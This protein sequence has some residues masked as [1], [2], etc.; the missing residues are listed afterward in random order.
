MTSA[1]QL[2]P[3]DV[4]ARLSGLRLLARLATGQG[5]GSHNSRARGAGL[6]F[7]QYRAYEPGDEPRRVDWKLYARSDRFFVREAE[8]DSPLTVWVIVDASASMAQVDSQAP[9]RSRITAA[10]TIA[11]CIAELALRQNDRFGLAIA[12]G[13]GLTVVDAAYGRRQ[14][15]RIDFEL[16]HVQP[17]GLFPAAGALRPVWEKIAPAALVLMISD[18]FEEGVTALA[19]KLA[20]AQREVA[21]VRVLT[22]DERDFRFEGSP[23][24][25]DP[26]SAGDQR[27]VDAVAARDE[28][29]QRFGAA[30]SELRR[31]LAAAGVRLE[32]HVT[33]EAAD[34][35]LRRLLRESA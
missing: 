34:G 20:A 25:R 4:Y 31:R 22:A 24:F 6:E 1:A 11:A 35:L 26:E 14:R 30:R 5:I 12:G 2:I 16:R 23:R 32:E 28:F 33:D 10:R 9:E 7:A 3:P 8:R 15:D 17:K 21:V 19:E 27:R 18:G 13:A 29:L